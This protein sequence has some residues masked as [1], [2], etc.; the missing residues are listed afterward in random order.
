MYKEQNG[1]FNA[2]KNNTLPVTSPS[3][4]LHSYGALH[5]SMPATL[6]AYK[7]AH[8]PESY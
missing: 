1:D 6:T 8:P 7:L 2:S 4:S 3:S 5:K